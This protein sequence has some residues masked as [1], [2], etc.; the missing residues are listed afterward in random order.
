M[1]SCFPLG[2][3]QIALPPLEKTQGFHRNAVDLH[4]FDGPG[5]GHDVPGLFRKKA[6]RADPKRQ[7]IVD[8]PLTIVGFSEWRVELTPSGNFIYLEKIRLS[9]LRSLTETLTSETLALS[10][11]C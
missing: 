4:N 11:T 9:F 5:V 1:C 8:G 6:P 7:S 3:E 2:L 10:R